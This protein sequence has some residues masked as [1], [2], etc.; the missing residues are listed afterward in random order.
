MGEHGKHYI[1]FNIAKRFLVYF[2]SFEIP[3][4]ITLYRIW[5]YE[6]SSC[7]S[8]APDHVTVFC[9]NLWWHIVELSYVSG[10]EIIGL[11]SELTPLVA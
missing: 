4:F 6:L 8:H 2:V 11:D 10:S 3:K 9:T 5:R 7:Y 1:D